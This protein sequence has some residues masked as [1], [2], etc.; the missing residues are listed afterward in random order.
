MTNDE[1]R[2]NGGERS[3]HLTFDI[4]R[5]PLVD[6]HCHLDWNAF[7]VDRDEVIRRAIG[8]GV[9]RM[10]TIGVDAPSSRR[11]LELAERYEAVYAAVGVHPNDAADFDNDALNELWALAQHSK[12][13]ALGEIG[14]DHYWKK[15][16]P[17]KQA[18]AF[19]AQIELAI[20]LGKPIIVH[21]RESMPDVL[22]ILERYAIGDTRCSGV[23]HSFSGDVAAAQRAFELGLLIGV[24]GP[25]TFKKADRLREIVRAAPIDRLV[26][27]TDAP[28]LAPVPHRGRRNE[29]AHVRLV[30]AHIARLRDMPFE[31]LAGRTTA[32]AAR[33]FG[34]TDESW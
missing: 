4:H 26:I 8:A 6:T 16:T 25:I 3:A 33:L 13:V 29:P 9:A 21:S 18:A 10:V 27:E 22:A 17:D 23:L 31:I 28:F 19:A 34:W 1:R 32:N 11:A 30:A 2:R 7:D 5:S 12:V 15:V 20:E 14:L 24:S